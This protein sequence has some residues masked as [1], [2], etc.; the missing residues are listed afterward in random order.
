MICDT[1]NDNS[2]DK[3]KFFGMMNKIAIN[4]GKSPNELNEAVTKVYFKLTQI[5]KNTLEKFASLSQSFD[6]NLIDKLVANK[7]LGSLIS[8]LL[9]GTSFHEFDEIEGEKITLENILKEQKWHGSQCN[10]KKE[11]TLKIF[12][13]CSLEQIHAF[14]ND[15]KVRISNLT[16]YEDNSFDD[17]ND[18][19]GLDD[20]KREYYL[21]VAKFLEDVA[22][23][24]PIFDTLEKAKQ[25]CDCKEFEKAKELLESL[26]ETLH[27]HGAVSDFLSE[28]EHNLML[29]K[30]FH[31]E[32][33]DDN[34]NQN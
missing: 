19:T 32:I 24:K 23:N 17:S 31:L 12:K 34:N 2:G 4:I 9:S 16:P 14:E 27:F 20:E 33:K 30:M 25:L 11:F 28:I 8:N 7:M 22:L 21:Q 26:D 1:K 6:S 29:Q 18:A 10:I 3:V 15:L 5:D 13:E